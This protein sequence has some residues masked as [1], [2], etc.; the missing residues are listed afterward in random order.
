MFE[1]FTVEW[2]RI[3]AVGIERSN[4][5]GDIECMILKKR[6]LI[7]KCPTWNDW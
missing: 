3:G 7:E 5:S 2:L 6:D 4:E 1:L